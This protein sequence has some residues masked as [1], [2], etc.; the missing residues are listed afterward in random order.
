V[1]QG[2]TLAL[3]GPDGGGPLPLG[4][5]LDSLDRTGLGMNVAYLVGH[6]EVRRW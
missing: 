6:N 4:P 3:G 5:Y 1:R 2:V